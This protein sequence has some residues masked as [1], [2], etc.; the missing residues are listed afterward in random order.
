MEIFPSRFFVI[1][2]FQ[3]TRS[4]CMLYNLT[5]SVIT[6]VCKRKRCSITLSTCLCGNTLVLVM[7]FVF[8]AHTS[9]ANVFFIASYNFCG[10][11]CGIRGWRCSWHLCDRHSITLLKSLLFGACPVVVMSICRKPDTFWEKGDDF[12]RFRVIH[13]RCT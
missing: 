12:T 10:Q 9:T 2:V 13:L 8:C 6:V 4:S 5:C 3:P 7:R 1:F 11:F